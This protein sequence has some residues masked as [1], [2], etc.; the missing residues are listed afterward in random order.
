MSQR[1]VDGVLVAVEHGTPQGAMVVLALGA[2]GDRPELA[3][4]L[5]PTAGVDDVIRQLR[6]A[7]AAATP[8]HD[9]H[10]GSKIAPARVG[11]RRRG[12][13]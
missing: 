13:V 7:A 9:C 11:H 5:C 6:R 4:Y 10:D 12:Q 8:L 1:L 3:T 2:A